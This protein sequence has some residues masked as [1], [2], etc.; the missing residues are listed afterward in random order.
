MTRVT[1]LAAALAATLCACSHPTEPLG[2]CK[3]LQVITNAHGD[4][5]AVVFENTN[6]GVRCEKKL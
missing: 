2:K 4:T 6:Q 1:K 3:V 5:L